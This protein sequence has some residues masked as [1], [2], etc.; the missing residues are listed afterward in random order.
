MR[1][2]EKA[3]EELEELLERGMTTEIEEVALA[4]TARAAPDL[5]YHAIERMGDKEVCIATLR[6]E[7]REVNRLLVTED[8]DGVYD[9]VKRFFLNL[10]FLSTE[11]RADK[12]IGIAAVTQFGNAVEYLP[13][14]L[15]ADKG[16]GLAAVKKWIGGQTSLC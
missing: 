3:I 9:A 13:A 10:T 11:F 1:T 15:R 2:E 6:Q 12:E 8:I 16:I 14:E 7:G 5:S 4:V